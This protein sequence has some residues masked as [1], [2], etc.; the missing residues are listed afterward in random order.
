MVLAAVFQHQGIVAQT[1]KHTENPTEKTQVNAP[2]PMDRNE[3]EVLD[4]RKSKKAKQNSHNHLSTIQ[5]L[6]DHIAIIDNNINN[7]AGMEEEVK[8]QNEKTEL[9]TEKNNLIRK[10]RKQ[11]QILNSKQD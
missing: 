1:L 6:D 5:S 10:V 4:I 11:K 2:I 9:V 7:A 3:S 8:L